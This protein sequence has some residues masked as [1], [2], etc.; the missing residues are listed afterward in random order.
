ML[1]TDTLKL[2]EYFI[3]DYNYNL[4]IKNNNNL[5][6]QLY[7]KLNTL[8]NINIH[9]KLSI[10]S[11]KNFDLLESSF[12]PK[13]IKNEIKKTN[14]IYTYKYNINNSKTI[15]Y[16]KFYVSEYSKITITQQKKMLK[17]IILLINFLFLYKSINIDS[18]TIHVHMS[19]HKKY[20]PNN[21][22]NILS[23]N[24]VNTAVTYA[25][26]SKGECIL[27]RKEEWF[28][29]LTHELMHSLC[30]DFSDSNYTLL[31]QKM[32]NLFPVNSTFYISETYAE[33]WAIILN[34]IF[35]SY[36]A[37]DNYYMFYKTFNFIIYFEILFSLFQLVKILDYM[38]IY[39]YTNLYENNSKAETL[40]TYYKEKSNVFSYYILKLIL[41]YNIDDTFTWIFRNNNIIQFQKNEKNFN[42]LYNLINYLKSKPKMLQDINKMKKYYLKL[43]NKYKNDKFIINT[44]RMSL[45][46]L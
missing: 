3:K 41:L 35:I 46:E 4:E 43:K 19:E 36:E 29:V 39:D 15:I 5:L 14:K 33:F 1:N 16:I 20:L 8:D 22:T 7:H 12:I 18:L 25:C 9:S 6:Q 28:K 32:H 42:D 44:M 45:F 27:Y 24:N 37:T 11:F 40:R 10:Q 2:I 13:H 17:K 26:S 30:L 31:K 38:N 23:Q 21:N 34:S